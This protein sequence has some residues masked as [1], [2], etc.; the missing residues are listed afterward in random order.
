MAQHKRPKFQILHIQTIGCCYNRVSLSR[1]PTNFKPCSG[2]LL[3]LNTFAE[4]FYIL[5]YFNH[6]QFKIC[7]N[8]FQ[9][10][11]KPT[12]I[13]PYVCSFY[14]LYYSPLEG[15]GYKLH[16]QRAKMTKLI[17]QIPCPFYH[18]TSWRKSALIQK[19]SAQI[20]KALHQHGKA[21]KKM[22]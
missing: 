1:F 2:T 9:I 6:I 15:V 10:K 13:L 12:K 17:L 7:S 3:A 16:A 11:Q 14:I 18:L 22:I 8:F 19:P 4:I 21:E 20:P 5:S